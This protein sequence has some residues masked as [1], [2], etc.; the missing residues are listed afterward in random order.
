MEDKRKDDFDK[1]MLAAAEYWKSNRSRMTLIRKI[2]CKIVFETTQPFEVDWLLKESRESDR[3]ISM[4]SVYRTLKG[5]REAEL[6]EE[7]FN[8]HEKGFYRLSPVSQ[9]SS[10]CIVCKNC[11]QTIP[12]DD[13]CLPIREGAQAQKKGFKATNVRL[14]TEATCDEFESTGNC[15]R[16]SDPEDD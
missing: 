10:S 5:L 9:L 8:K 15:E 12:V 4:A 13:P 1:R 2:V 16:G 3:L 11:G 6:V 14:Q 7:F